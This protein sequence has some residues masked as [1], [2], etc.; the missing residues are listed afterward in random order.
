MS[1]DEE[2]QTAPTDVAWI[3]EL[4]KDSL[5]AVCRKFNVQPKAT[6]REIRIQL[7]EFLGHELPKALGASTGSA[8]ETG[9]AA[10]S[11]QNPPV[12]PSNPLTMQV[13]RKWG[14]SFDNSSAISADEFLLRLEENCLAYQIDRDALLNCLPGLLGG[15]PLQWYRLNRSLWTTWNAFRRDF[16]TMYIAPDY[17]DRL[18]EEIRARTQGENESINDFVVS[19]CSL[20]SRLN[21][22]PNEETQIK[23]IFRNL[24]PDYLTYVK[25]SEVYSIPSLLK[26]GQ[27]LELLRERQR[28]YRPPPAKEEAMIPELAYDRALFSKGGP[29]NHPVKSSTEVMVVNRAIPGE[30]PTP[31]TT[32]R[33][34]NCRETG[35]FYEHCP[36]PRRRFCSNCGNQRAGTEA[37]TRC[38]AGNARGRRA[39]G[40]QAAP[41]PTTSWDP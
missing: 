37:C 18:E 33:C 15:L 25:R 28:T 40:T 38:D 17:Q 24:H 11:T 30:H 23:W 1:S 36:Q 34:W 3:Y 6:V 7:R 19:L 13:V 31:K 29:T 32:R 39:S 12:L 41:R 2:R 5:L 8:K 21:P 16:G 14:L 26:R 10:P 27:E 9:P 20:L 35:H 22:P 4:K